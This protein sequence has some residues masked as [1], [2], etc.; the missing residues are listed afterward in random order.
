[1]LPIMCLLLA[2]YVVL[3]CLE[4]W[5]V[6]LSHW[7]SPAIGTFIRIWAGMTCLGTIVLAVSVLRSAETVRGDILAVLKSPA[8]IATVLGVG[9]LLLFSYGWARGRRFRI[10]KLIARLNRQT[11]MDGI[12]ISRSLM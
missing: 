11:V 6:D 12:D 4:I 2:G 7:S 10:R 8:T 9:L 3:R 5:S 1:M